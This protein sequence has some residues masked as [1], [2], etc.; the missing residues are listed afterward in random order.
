MVGNT[1]TSAAGGGGGCA[2]G[3]A[4]GCGAID[5]GEVCGGWVVHT[6]RTSV[7][8]KG[9]CLVSTRRTAGA[10][11]ITRDGRRDE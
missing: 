11:N 4:I 3:I 10:A 7:D 1:D 6:V 5:E 2:G 9:E 8:D